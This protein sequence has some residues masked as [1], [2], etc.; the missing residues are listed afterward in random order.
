[1][2]LRISI[3]ARRIEGPYGGGNQFANTL[4]KYLRSKGHEVFRK[5]V[6]NLDLILIVSFGS[7]AGSDAF[8]FEVTERIEEVR[9]LAPKT[10]E[11]LERN[12]HYLTYGQYAKYRQKI[13]K[14]P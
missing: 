7:G 10:R 14:A 8:I 9:D 13:R 5:L 4:E 1:M 3:N 12:K 2:K 11:L 6:P